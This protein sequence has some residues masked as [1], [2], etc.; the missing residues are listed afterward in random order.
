MGI[1]PAYGESTGKIQVGKYTY[2]S[3]WRTD[4]AKRRAIDQ[5]KEGVKSEEIEVVSYPPMLKEA[6][7]RVGAVTMAEG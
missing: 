5:T 2:S 3:V 1:A 4:I 6:K 7:A